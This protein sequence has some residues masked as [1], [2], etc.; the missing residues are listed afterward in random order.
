[1]ETIGWVG[2]GAMGSAMA[3][4]VAAA[5][6]GLVVFARG[7]ASA[8]RAAALGAVVVDDPAAV[9]AAADAVVTVVS[10]PA[11]VREVYLAERGLLA[12]ARAGSLLVDMS[13]S[14]PELARQIASRAGQVGALAVDAPVSGGPVAAE[15][16]TLSIMVGGEPE[17]V[18][19]ARPLL[20]LLGTTIVHQ[21]GPGSGQETKLANQV[22]L[23]GSMLGICEAFLF[24]RDRGLD[25]ERVLEAIAGGIAGSALTRFVW[26]RLAAAEMEGGFGIGLMVKD[27]R[28]A[29]ECG[30]LPGVALVLSLY[31]RALAAGFASAG[32]Q[33]LVAGLDDPRRWKPA[34]PEEAP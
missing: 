14:S 23:A 18:E 13:T 4:H 20:A 12:G 10:M 27:L 16:A 2:L 30:D 3:A 5:G 26:T 24:A 32:S 9:A 29:L 17:A 22:A 19:R 25:Q 28:L 34:H 15:A 8:E 1:V 6:H 11:D 31:D 33:A 7:A 21:G